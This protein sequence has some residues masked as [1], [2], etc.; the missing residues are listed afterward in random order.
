MRL[1][2]S[3]ILL[4][5]IDATATSIV[6]RDFAPAR[7]GEPLARLLVFTLTPIA[8]ISSALLARIL[9]KAKNVRLQGR[10]E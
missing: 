1:Q 4:L 7:E 10:E 3:F 2:I 6:W 5:I 8:L 9:L